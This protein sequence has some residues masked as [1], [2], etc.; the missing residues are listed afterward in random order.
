MRFRVLTLLMVAL[1]WRPCSYEAKRKTES[2]VEQSVEK[3]HNQLNEIS[4]TMRFMRRSD[5]VLHS[6]I[7]EAEF[8]GQLIKCPR[9][10]SAT[11]RIRQYVHN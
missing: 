7:G 4:S 10:L 9:R 8:T 2:A 3:F 1:G 6:R 5:P 11:G